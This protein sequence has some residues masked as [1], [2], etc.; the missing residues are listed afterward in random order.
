MGAVLEAAWVLC[1][2][3]ALGRSQEALPGPEARPEPAPEVAEARLP[4]RDELLDTL[5]LLEQPGPEQRAACG[6]R[7]SSLARAAAPTLV[8]ALALP[9]AFA[10][11]QGPGSGAGAEEALV[12]ALRERPAAEVLPALHGIL[13]RDLPFESERRLIRVMGLLGDAS[14]TAALLD[15]VAAMAPARRQL[16]AIQRELEAALA[17]ILRRHPEACAPLAVASERR[18][19]A[20]QACIARALG[21]A[22]GGPALASLERMAGRSLELDRAVLE[23][24]GRLDPADPDCLSG[25]AALLTWHLTSGDA[26]A[27]RTAAASLARHGGVEQ[28]DGLTALLDDP[29]PRVRRAAQH[30]LAEIA[31]MDL[32]GQP[33]DWSAWLAR[34]RLWYQERTP[35]LLAEASAGAADRAFE[36]LRELSSHPLF[37]RDLAEPLAALLERRDPGLA[38][39]ACRA[40]ARLGGPA[41]I[42]PLESALEDERA[43]V[44]QAAEAAL[45]ILLHL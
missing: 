36:A 25:C 21:S 45:A 38:S 12:A 26:D 30:A 35:A 7:L 34:E 15:L 32:G 44:A 39:A 22:G 33:G 17:Q 16:H 37:R 41:A 1:L 3:G 43:D 11:G 6:E 27:R 19:I 10:G 8:E 24:V 2:A 18:E 23:A 40:L 4:H 31:R 9:E 13:R 29:D 20:L 42:A 14:S 5:A 28:V